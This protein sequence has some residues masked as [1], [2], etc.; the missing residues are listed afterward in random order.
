MTKKEKIIVRDSINS[1]LVL[2]DL[3]KISDDGLNLNK[4]DRYQRI[5]VERRKK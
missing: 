4:N 2:S 3:S 5:V 1:L